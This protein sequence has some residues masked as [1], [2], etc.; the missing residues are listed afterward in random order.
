MS[1]AFF[2]AFLFIYAIHSFIDFVFVVVVLF[3]P[4]LFQISNYEFKTVDPSENQEPVLQQDTDHKNN[5][6]HHRTHFFLEFWNYIFQLYDSIF[7]EGQTLCKTG[8]RYMVYWIACV[9][10]ARVVAIVTLDFHVYILVA[11]FYLLESLVFEYEGFSAKSMVPE[12]ARF[13]SSVSFA[14]FINTCVFLLWL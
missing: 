11:I 9:G 13:M 12:K 3:D 8:K 6:A 4:L 10:I 7:L 14:L 2:Y 1:S 5:F